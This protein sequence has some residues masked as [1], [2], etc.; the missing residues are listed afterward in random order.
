MKNEHIPQ[1]GSSIENAMRI[2]KIFSMH[3]PEMRLVDIADELG[4]AKSTAHRLLTTLASEGFVY[5]DPQSN[6]YSL[7][8]SVLAL[9][10]IVSSQLSIV[11][12]ATPIL[13]ALTENTRESSHLAIREG[14]EVIYLQ[15]IENEYSVH[16]TT[17]IGRRNPLH[18]TS[19]GLAILAFETEEVVDFI[20]SKPLTKFTDYTI[21]DPNS[22]RER[23][24][25]IRRSGVVVDYQGFERK[26][27]SIGAPIFNS[28]DKVIASVNIT[29]PVNRLRDAGAQRKCV[30][31][32]VKTAKRISNLVKLR[33]RLFEEVKK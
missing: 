18:C 22:L 3:Q 24:E 1:R 13:N 17:H 11:E 10:N 15:K 12:E 21:T 32:V 28:Q 23:L 6:Y 29:A 2:L 26:V 5:K 33:K 27:I 25:E 14:H 20:L 30:E 7:G 31:E 19:T 9:T 16:V 4:I 8:V